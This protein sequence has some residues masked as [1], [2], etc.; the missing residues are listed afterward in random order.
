MDM[1]ATNGD[2]CSIN[3]IYK[4]ENREEAFAAYN[5]AR[6]KREELKNSE[7]AG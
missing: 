6:H 4:F 7:P 3:K 1:V 2:H 5:E